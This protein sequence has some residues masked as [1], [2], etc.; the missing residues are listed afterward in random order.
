MD[1]NYY[2][3]MMKWTFAFAVLMIAGCATKTPTDS[4]SD[5]NTAVRNPNSITPDNVAISLA[6]Y[7]KR[8]PGVQVMQSASGVQVTV[9][10]ANSLAGNLEPL[11]VVD[12]VNV[13][14]GYEKAEPL[15]PVADIA[16]VQVLKS[17]QET[18][19]YGMQGTNGVIV[20]RTKRK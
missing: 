15:V 6:D 2:I 16:S 14:F 20:I 9:R 3:H 12:G 10:G 19:S 4:A 13:G 11:F 18:A 1:R 5:Q 7:L 17:G 8:V